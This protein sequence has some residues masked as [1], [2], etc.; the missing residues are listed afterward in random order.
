MSPAKTVLLI[1][2]DEVTRAALTSLLEEQGYRVMGAGDGQ[3]ALH[4]LRELAHPDLII[5]DL[6]MPVLSGWEFREHQRRDPTLAGIP[7][8][9]L[10]AAVESAQKSTDLG[11]V[12]Y[13][14]KPI[15]PETLLPL[16]RQFTSTSL[17]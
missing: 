12:A 6:M 14:A 3:Q 10:S 2:D 1:E 7:V 17:A 9:V 13:L 4:L 5:L 15:W 16:V 11:N 8:I